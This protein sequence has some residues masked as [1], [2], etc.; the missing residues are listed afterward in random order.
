MSRAPVFVGGMFKSGTTLLRAMLSQHS[1]IASG[2]ETYWFSWN[3]EQRQG[4]Q[5]QEA[6]DRLSTFFDL[7]REA[8][9]ALAQAAPTSEDF[10]DRMMRMVAERDGKPRWAEKTPGNVAHVDRIWA[11]WQ[12]AQVVHIIRDPRDIFASLVEARKWDTAE[13]FASRWCD[14]VGQGERLRVRLQPSSDRYLAIRY[15]E[16]IGSPENTMRTV[17]SFLGET[18]EPAAAKFEGRAEDFQKVRDATGKESTTLARLRQPLGGERVGIWERVLSE[19]QVE[20]IRAAVASRGFGD[21]YEQ[22]TR[23]AAPAGF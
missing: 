9:I 11:H 5:F 23:G 17:V 10:L 3:W 2:L 4:P 18:W 20:D 6:L 8:L 15:E 19:S 7:D 14:I 13:D 12:D 16:L 21:L 22:I 1:A